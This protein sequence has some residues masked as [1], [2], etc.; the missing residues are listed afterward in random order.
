MNN[1]KYSLK[2]KW[3]KQLASAIELDSWGQ[4]VESC[5]AYEKYSCC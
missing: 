3:I 5:E 4:V 2:A 1:E